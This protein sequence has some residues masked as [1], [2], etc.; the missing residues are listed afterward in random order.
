MKPET[1]H[2]IAA[3]LNATARLVREISL[4]LAL[5]TAPAGATP[6]TLPSGYDASIV[7]R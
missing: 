6:Q 1:L 7:Q 2:G 5:I 4:A 3:V